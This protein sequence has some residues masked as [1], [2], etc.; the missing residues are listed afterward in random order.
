MTARSIHEPTESSFLSEALQQ[1]HSHFRQ[2][3]SSIDRLIEA[4][5]QEDAR[6]HLPKLHALGKELHRLLNPRDQVERRNRDK[7]D[8]EIERIEKALRKS[9]SGTVGT[10]LMAT[11]LGGALGVI[12][13]AGIL[14]FVF[15]R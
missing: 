2:L 12:T 10:G 15:V 14:Y 1:S 3:V 6:R 13:L 11:L 4:D 5:R 7:I 8:R 9:L